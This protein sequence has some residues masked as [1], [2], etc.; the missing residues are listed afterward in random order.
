MRVQSIRALRWLTEWELFDRQYV[1]T[2]VI[3]GPVSAV[4]Q[5]A[6]G[7]PV[8]LGITRQVLGHSQLL[9]TP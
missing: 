1:L 6:P 9:G 5:P 7:L 8:K 4:T 3:C 2:G